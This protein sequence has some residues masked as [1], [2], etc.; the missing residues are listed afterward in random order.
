MKS[1]LLASFLSA[2]AL[3]SACVITTDDP[4]YVE[5]G[6]GLLTLEWTLGGTTD[7]GEC[8]ATDAD[9]I[10]IS[11]RQSGGRVVDQF[12]ESCDRFVASVELLPGTYQAEAVL[13]DPLDRERTTT[14]GMGSFEIY[15]DDEL[16]LDVDFP[17]SSF[18]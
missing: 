16:I 15:G 8:D 7:P 12:V 14:A 10:E 18:Y 13:L 5:R 9:V 6:N 11:I 17:P 1:P 4:V 2:L 3:T